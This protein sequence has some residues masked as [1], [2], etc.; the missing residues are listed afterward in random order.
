MQPIIAKANA[1]KRDIYVVKQENT[2]QDTR[3]Q[4]TVV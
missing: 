3:Q 2:K 4:M 1:K